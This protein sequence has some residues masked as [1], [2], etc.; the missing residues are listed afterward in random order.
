MGNEYMDELIKIFASNSTLITDLLLWITG[1]IIIYATTVAFGRWA[2]DYIP[3]KKQRFL[4]QKT[5]RICSL[6]AILAIGVFTFAAKLSSLAIILGGV[7]AG[8]AF[9]L[10]G[11]IVSFAGWVALLTARSYQVGDRILIN[12]I[13]GDVIDIGLLYTTV[14]ELGKWVDGD[15]Y[16]G[17]IVRI[18][19][20]EALKSPVYNYT[21]DFSFLWDE[22]KIP[23]RYGSNT[24]EAREVLENIALELTRDFASEVQQNWE[25]ITRRYLIEKAQVLPMVTMT[26]NDNWIEF[27]VRYIVNCRERRRMQD[28][29]FERILKEFEKSKEL[30]FASATF[31]LVAAPP[32]TL[33][34]AQQEELS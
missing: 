22:I 20:S 21:R 32:L 9:A 25:N 33:A 11:V 10:Q 1:A 15:L 30:Q 5:I 18:P 3:D 6:F 26:A 13:K 24:D 34:G 29:L 2:A 31:E 4:I 7:S 19:N 23:V 27:T 8:V 28:R 16:N 17:R 12:N 14:M